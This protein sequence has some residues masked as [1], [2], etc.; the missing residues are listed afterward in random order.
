MKR[1]LSG[2]EAFARGAYEA[3]VKVATGYPGTPSTEILEAIASHYKDAIYCEWSPNEKVAF[4]VAAGAYVAGAR[5]L[6][7]M[8]HVGLNV[9]ADPLMTL[10]YTGGKG[11]FV[12]IIA[13]DPG[14]HSSQ[15]EQDTRHFARFA[16]VPILEPSSSQEAKDYVRL[17]FELSEEY[18]TPV[19][20]R[21]TTRVSHSRGL[22]EERPRVESP[23]EIAFEKDPQRQVAV[24]QWSRQM[25]IVVEERMGRLTEAACRSEMNRIEWRDRKVGIIASGIVYQYVRDVFPVASVLKLGFSYP[26]PDNLIHEF[27]DGVETLLIVEELDDFLEEHIRSLGIACIGKKVIP[28]IGELTPT[29]LAG[30]RAKFET[31]LA[32]VESYATNVNAIGLERM[33][34]SAPKSDDLPTRPPVLCPGCPHRGVFF[35][36]R[37]F[38][39]DVTGDIGCYSLGALKPLD[40]I[41]TILCMGAGVSMA[42]G[43]DKAGNPKKV[44]GIVGDSTFFHSGITGLLDIAYNKGSAT[45]IVVDNRT[46]A[47]TGRQE[48]P[49][50]GRTLMGAKTVE[51]SIEGVALACGIKNVVTVNPYE[52]KQVRAV[53]KEATE[54]PEAWLIVSK[55]PCPLQSKKKL[56][57]TPILDAEKCRNCKLCLKL[58]CPAIEN[59]G[60]RITINPLLCVGCGMCDAICPFDALR[61]EEGDGA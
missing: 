6:V 2:N 21:S 58:G 7:T 53:L 14:M 11:G 19:L 26:F 52:M 41:D 36:L 3:G 1:L 15:N 55:A 22:V 42:H 40:R 43:M 8:K 23:I 32:D 56:G 24:P 16:K 54:S 49:G 31:L 38:Q 25:R 39:V 12:A 5:A 35:S 47:M 60:G 59:Q 28:K 20:L 17:G 33:S 51:A 18:R 27:A 46:T 9:A 50:S 37:R 44:V 48:N 10:S 45:I 61:P 4:E 34:P 13:D 29:I 57:P 30:C